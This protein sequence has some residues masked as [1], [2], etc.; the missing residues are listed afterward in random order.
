[1]NAQAPLLEIEALSVTYRTARGRVDAVRDVTGR[2]VS[3][4]IA[5][6]RAGDAPATVAASGKARHDL[7]W[8]PAKPGLREIIADAWAFHQAT[9]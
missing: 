6:R 1:M 5:P 8:R 2:P 4:K 3:V 7:G 9:W